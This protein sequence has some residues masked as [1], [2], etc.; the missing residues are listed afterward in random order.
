MSLSTPFIHRPVATT[1]LT[2]A[3]A[4]AGAIA[5]TVLPVS[6]LPQVDFPTIS[7]GASLPGASADIMASSI[8]TPLE[9]QFGHIAGVTE[10]TSSSSLGA[11][12]ITIQF[13][14]SRNIDG[15]AR[16]VEAAINAARTYLPTNL[17][18]NPTYRKVN[19]ADSPIMIIALTS[20]IY[21][22]DKLYDEASTVMEQKLSQI[23][24]VG[25]VSAGG[26]ALPS[27]RVEVNPTK[28]ASYGLAMSDLQA[29]LSLQNTNLARGQITNGDA[30]ADIV[31]NGQI[32]H[33]EEYKPLIVGYHNGTAIHLSDVSDVVDS[34]QNVRAG[35]YLNGKRAIV[36][37][38]FR[39]PGANIIDTVDRI[40]EQMPSLQATIPQGITITKVL[41]RTTTI[42]AS[43]DDVERTLILSVCLVIVV[44]FIFLRNGRAT[45]IPAV[46]VPVSLI[47]TFAIMYMCGY[48]LDNLSLMALTIS[49]GFVVDD[50]IVVM[51]NI[52]RHI[53]DGVAPFAAA[54]KGAQEIGF[55]VVSI[56]ISLIAV[57]IPLLLMGGIVGRLF[58]EF[59]VTLST[60]ILVSMAVSLTTTPMMCAYLLKSEHN[61]KHGRLYMAMEGAFDWVLNI[62]RKSLHWVLGNP[63]LTLTVLFLT[64]A[65]NVVIIIKIPKGFFPQQDTG[66]LSGAIRGPQDASY[67]V[68][69]AS[70]LQAEEV[71]KKD[72]SVQNVIGF[73]GGQGATNTGNLFVILKPL[74]IRKIGAPDIINRLRAPLNKLTGASTFLQASQDLR[75][76]GRSSNALYQYTI[77][78]DNV[79][80][81]QTWG[82]KLLEQMTHLHG[83]QDVSSDQQNG[84][85]DEL[86]SYDRVTAAKLGQTAQSLDNGLYGAF[87]QSEVSLI[88]TQLN[89]YYVVLEVAPQY[90]AHPEGLENI[91]F[92]D[93]SSSSKTASGNTPLF[94]MARASANT[95]PL[96]LNHTGLFPSVTVSFNLAPGVSL[97]EA[98][99]AIEQMQQKLGTPTSIQGFFAGTL[100][101]YQQSLGTEPVLVLTALIAVYI[102]LGVLYESLMHPLTIL[103]TLPSA[104]VGAMLALMLFKE[105]L[106]VIS[107]IGIVLLIGIVKKNAI[108]MIDFAL[109]QEREGGMNTEDAIFEACMLRFRPI[110]MT[111][112]AALF[113]ALP[114]AF[115]TGTGSELRRPLGITI[116]GGLIVSQ[117][118]TLYTTPVVYLTLDKLRLRMSGK[119]HDDFHATDGLAASA[120]E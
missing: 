32:S 109:Q 16:D 24:G 101:A 118:L 113:G 45:L 26:G 110:L 10:M 88:Y 17:P 23:E 9:R 93:A 95:T 21:G 20:D 87:G 62:Y 57:F 67:P 106:N 54:L 33:A 68:M 49:T 97:S 19:P 14:L 72:P 79:T 5:F 99:L 51:E 104:S 27:V 2:I 116:V 69:N 102:V 91:Y 115:G 64:I 107:I 15:A 119:E 29:M 36:L 70:L 59:A 111:T 63:G 117:L 65:L 38:V 112:M 66:T 46:A 60:A 78:A 108:M 103:S 41:D 82:P 90:W 47:G 48:S 44:V 98:T 28:L 96:A 76:G 22:P 105:D 43:V 30:S 89:Q 73:T 12:S 7:V 114:L 40:D 56:S 1:L 53:E 50:A 11:T 77:E 4:I 8:A 75:I 3:V 74:N 80:D 55:T 71:I 84:G 42:R 52:T 37:I 120:S 86:L 25:Q 61:K 6:P 92:H 13:D 94:T 18:S 35:G 31:V 58:R 39:Q 34:V 100:Q 83:L 81:L 85:L